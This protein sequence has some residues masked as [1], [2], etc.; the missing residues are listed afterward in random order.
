MNK[1]HDIMTFFKEMNSSLSSI[2]G[3]IITVSTA[4]NAAFL[5]MSSI[6]ISNKLYESDNFST[7]CGVAAAFTFINM[8]IIQRLHCLKMECIASMQEIWKD[9][10]CKGEYASMFPT[11]LLKGNSGGA[12]GLS[13]TIMST[14]LAALISAAAA[15]SIKIPGGS[16]N[17]QSAVIFLAVI[18]YAIRVYAKLFFGKYERK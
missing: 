18:F 16:I 15:G 4:H 7:L 11:W 14:L 5:L 13:F 8:V 12:V 2:D 10:S 3:R 6:A 1:N 17:I 9:V